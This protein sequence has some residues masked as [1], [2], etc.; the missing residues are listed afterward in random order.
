M[1]HSPSLDRKIRKIRAAHPPST[2]R[3]S[4]VSPLRSARA[5]SETASPEARRL[6]RLSKLQEKEATR[7][8]KARVEAMLV[9]RFNNVYNTYDG[10]PGSARAATA[11]NAVR[12]E[13]LRL[14]RDALQGESS[15]E[16]TEASVAAL[17][18]AVRLLS[19]Q[20]YAG[21][22]RKPNGQG[23]RRYNIISNEP[24]PELST[25]KLPAAEGS[26]SPAPV[27]D[28]PTT[29]APVMNL[30]LEQA[31]PWSVMLAVDE[32]KAEKKR[33][34]QQLTA[35]RQRQAL[36]DHLDE[37]MRLQREA[38]ERERKEAARFH[39]MQMREV[40][41]WRVREEKKKQAVI[42][43]Y[44][45]ERRWRD[46]QIAELNRRRD[47]EQRELREEEAA[48]LARVRAKLAAEEERRSREK[49]RTLA[50]MMQ[51]QN[52]IRQQQ[53]AR[54]VQRELEAEQDARLMEEYKA[55]LEK[56][57]KDRAEAF[58][59][60]MARY[61]AIGEQWA[62]KGAGA[63]QAE[64]EAQMDAMVLRE[65]QKKER[66]DHEREVAKKQQQE[67]YKRRMIADNQRLLQEKQQI[68]RAQAAQEEAYAAQ[69][70]QEFVDWQRDEDMRQS[71]K[72]ADQAQYQRVLEDQIEEAKRRREAEMGALSPL[73]NRARA[74]AM[75]QI[76]ADPELGAR[77]MQR[78]AVQQRG[79]NRSNVSS[80]IF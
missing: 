25:S 5:E 14:V 6:N 74:E 59:K 52:D 61:E 24:I 20:H 15:E 80:D 23:A 71:K 28:E 18:D 49:E 46:R 77:V 69:Y 30:D 27:D 73:Q 60:R 44:Q 31:D 1:K 17:D 78:I 64:I 62:K 66:M 13:I 33:E 37:Q 51:V 26:V 19:E 32:V 70:Q 58:K 8:K 56:Q 34:Q 76:N 50:Q 11:Q 35:R 39:E 2:L 22:D 72:L 29:T 67:E 21:L 41:V 63:Q 7:A 12:K 43:K 79:G 3:T 54:V 42:Q 47:E 53:Q 40:E 45:E 65:S 9:K 75:D 68:K 10:P 57:E 36:R 55:R 4:K 16:L 48:N 38:R